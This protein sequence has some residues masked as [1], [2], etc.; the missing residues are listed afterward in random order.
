MW[1]CYGLWFFAINFLLLLPLSILLTFKCDLPKLLID[2]AIGIEWLTFDRFLGTQR[3][4]F[5]FGFGGTQVVIFLKKTVIWLLAMF[6]RK[7][8][9]NIVLER[10]P[11]PTIDLVKSVGIWLVEFLLLLKIWVVDS[12]EI[13]V[14]KFNVFELRSEDIH[15]AAILKNDF[16]VEARQSFFCTHHRLILDEGFPNLGL[17]K[18]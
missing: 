5:V 2:V 7:T 4:W 15:F 13:G 12:S 3:L 9:L 6:M 14:L 1:I 10:A 17:F 18:D 8:R 16:I 11:P